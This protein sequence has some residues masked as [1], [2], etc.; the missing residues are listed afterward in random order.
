MAYS[1]NPSTNARTTKISLGIMNKSGEFRK[2]RIKLVD[3]TIT[4][5]GAQT[6]TFLPKE[7]NVACD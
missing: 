6:P 4:V 7:F 1:K 2:L 3:P 5:D